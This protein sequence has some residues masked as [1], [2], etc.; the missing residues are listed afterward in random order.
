M[1]GHR[2]GLVA[3]GDEGPVG[4]VVAFPGRLWGALRLGTGV[5]LARAAGV[6]HGLDLVKRG[7]ILDRLHPW[8]PSSSLY[9]SALSVKADDRKQGI[10][11]R[12]MQRVVAGAGRLGLGVTLDVDLENEP[13][14]RL[15]EKL[16]FRTLDERRAGPEEGELIGGPGF[17]RMATR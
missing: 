16:G 9:V 13:A 17:A 11:E 3:V 7:V 2:F 15:Y 14:I 10:G 4:L 12:L 5:I 6:S 1:F 8:C